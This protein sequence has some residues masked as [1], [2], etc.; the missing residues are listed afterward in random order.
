M[1]YLFYTTVL[2]ALISNKLIAQQLEIKGKIIDKETQEPLIGIAVLIKGTQQGIATD[3]EGNFILNSSQ[4]VPFT[5]VISGLGYIRQEFS[6]TEISKEIQVMLRPSVLNTD[7]VVI[8]ASRVEESVMQSPV[9]IE[10]LTIRDLRETPAPSLFDAMESV[11]GVQMT[12]LSMGFKVPNTR[13]FANTTNARFLSMVDG[14]DTQAPGLGVSI[15][16][17]VGPTELDVESIEIIPGASSALYGLN[18]LNGTSNMITKSPFLYTG[19]SFY[20]QLGLNHVNSTQFAPQIFNQSALRYAYKINEKWAF[21]VNVGWMKGTDWVANSSEEL[22][23]NSNQSTGLFGAENPGSNPLNSY[24]N[25][26]QNRKNL[27]L[28]DGKRYEVRRTGYYEKDL[29]NNDYQVSNLKADAAVH[30]KPNEKTEASY[31]YRIGTTDAIYQRGNRIRLDNYQIQQHKLAIKGDSYFVQGYLTREHTLDSYNL[32]PIGENMDRAFKSDEVWY[33]EYSSDYNQVF[34]DGQN[35]A[36][37][38]AQARNE[39]DVGRFQPGTPEFNQKLNDLAHINNWDIGAQLIMEHSFYHFEGQ[40]DFKNLIQKVDIL[41]GIDFRDFTIHP[42][43]NSFTNPIGEDPFATLHYKKVGGFVQLSK[44]FWDEKLKILASGR[45]DKTQYFDA[46]FNPRLAAVFSPNE[47]HH[48]RAS[49]QN[50]FRFPTLFEAFSTVNNGGV[51]RYGGLELMS[52]DQQ[53]FENSYLRTSV[54]AFQ[55]ANTTTIN[56]GKTTREALIENSST[57]VRN[58]YTYLVP[59]EIK[60][61]DFGYKA[62][63]LGNRLFLDADFYYNQYKNFIDQIEIAVPNFGTIGIVDG[64]VDPTWFEMENNSLHTRYRMWTNSKSIYQNFGF[65]LGLSYN[66]FKKMV[67]SGNYSH[68][69]LSKIDSRDSGLETP[70]N[71]P[72]HILNLNLTD[73]ELLK[74][75]GYSIAYRWES[76]FDWNAPL[77]NGIV[78]SYQT[79]DAQLS[80]KVPAVKTTFKLGGTNLLNKPYIQYIGG[81]EISGFYYLA[82]TLDGL[83]TQEQ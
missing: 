16:N 29:V 14:A 47:Q 53:L 50:G 67:L 82:V 83:F 17:T 24:G 79:I 80:Y 78:P 41:A 3:L 59:E 26:N 68:A 5:L 51:I 28:A 72:K 69:Q 49:I 12:T 81:P 11:K 61:I 4:S 60:A 57:L 18:A 58:D 75:L 31:V 36:N 46:K 7:E 54:D 52:K 73:R 1:K 45:L 70:F 2:L 37:A 76:S 64:E 39:A 27:T 19:F 63:L 71:T 21:K 10:K 23:P 13:G 8:T 66:F 22:S 77:A 30:F 62:S 43:G 44:R 25:E 38:H 35:P 55:Q 15:A 32:R 56:N 40:Y 20:Q 34:A 6:I 9:A 65:S 42:E 48:I 74:N 33:A